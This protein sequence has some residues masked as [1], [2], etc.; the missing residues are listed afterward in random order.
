MKLPRVRESQT[1]INTSITSY[2]SVIKYWNLLINTARKRLPS[3]VLNKKYWE[4]IILESPKVLFIMFG[5]KSK[6][7]TFI[8][9]QKINARTLKKLEPNEIFNNFAISR[10]PFDEIDSNFFDFKGMNKN[11]TPKP[12]GPD[13]AKISEVGADWKL[14][15]SYLGI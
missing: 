9:H 8:R 14:I 3:T 7:R 6:V 5:F 15:S 1:L 11:I 10:E 13:R 4:L 2:R 12:I